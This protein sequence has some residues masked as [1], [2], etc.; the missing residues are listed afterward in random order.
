MDRLCLLKQPELVSEANHY[1]K[2]KTMVEVC[3]ASGINFALMCTHNINAA[4]KQLHKDGKITDEGT[5][6]D[7]TYTA[8]YE[9][10]K[11]LADCLS[12]EIF[13]QPGSCR[14]PTTGCMRHRNRSSRMT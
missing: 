2:F 9:D 1:E 5:F 4:M 14:Y 10:D 12:E 11:K 7:G 6:E 8:L 3:K 13:Y